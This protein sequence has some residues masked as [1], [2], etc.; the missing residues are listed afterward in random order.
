MSRTEGSAQKRTARRVELKADFVVVGGSRGVGRAIVEKLVERVP[1]TQIGVSVRD[2]EKADNLA[3]LGHSAAALSR[4]HAVA[5]LQP[6]RVT[7]TPWFG[8]VRDLFA[9]A[10]F[11]KYRSAG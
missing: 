7:T 3:A 9:S 6:L 10:H 1:A 11:A 4:L 2:P 5:F 8:R